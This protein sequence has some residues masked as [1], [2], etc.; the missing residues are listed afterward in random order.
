MS[1]Q[2]GLLQASYKGVGFLFRTTS[3]STGRKIIIDEYPKSDNRGTQ[4]LGK[5]LAIYD[6]QI[7]VTGLGADYFANKNQLESVLESK[8]A[9]IFVHPTD[10]QVKAL[11]S[12]YTVVE[13]MTALGRASYK[14]TFVVTTNPTFPTATQSAGAGVQ[15]QYGGAL[16]AIGNAFNTAY[17]VT[18]AYPNAVAQ[19]R[20]FTQQ[21]A[22]QFQTT[23]TLTP[24]SG[25]TISDYTV[26][27]QAMQNNIAG[28]ALDGST[29]STTV[30][31][32]FT[33]MQKLSPDTGAVTTLNTSFFGFNLRGETP[34]DTPA[35][36]QTEHNRR[37]INLYVNSTALINQY[38]NVSN[39]SFLTE[40]DITATSNVLD[41]QYFTVVDNNTWVDSFGTPF[42]LVDQNA[43]DQ[44]TML[45]DSMTSFLTQQLANAK[46][47]NTVYVGN[48]GLVTLVYDL[49][50]SL[51][52]YDA[53]AQ[54]NTLA[55]QTNVAGEI[56]VLTS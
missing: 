23:P 16:S 11:V 48:S 44:I 14:V 2:D 30:A 19:A 6:L 9:G 53:I 8:D 38:L 49:Y 15:N 4:D 7:F 32:I 21:L 25:S 42:S 41:A 31:N 40:D 22:N 26:A 50:E 24:V 43:I 18:S 52:L 12:L 3:K 28:N 39:Q 10:G 54:L 55:N 37:L 56:K 34:T 36:V 5:Y 17:V 13:D 51:D 29:F 33:L 35:R 46:Q 47:I 27:V 20:R 1:V 45:R